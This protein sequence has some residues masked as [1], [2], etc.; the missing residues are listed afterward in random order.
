VST[1]RFA[2]AVVLLFLAV[3]VPQAIIAYPRAAFDSIQSDEQLIAMTRARPDDPTNALTA[4][5]AQQRIDRELRPFSV[6]AWSVGGACLT[7]SATLC[8]ATLRRGKDPH[9]APAPAAR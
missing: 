5:R 6:L 2:L 1:A 4:V 7:A 9:Q 3:A 8:Y